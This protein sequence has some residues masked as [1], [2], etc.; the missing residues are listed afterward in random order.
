[1]KTLSVCMIVRNEEKT[2]E[3]AIKNIHLFADQLVI[4]DTGST[5]K[6]VEIAKK[7]TNEVYFFEWCDNFA[8]AQNFATSFSKCD[9]DTKWDADFE[10]DANSANR[11]LQAKKND[12]DGSNLIY[13]TWVIEHGDKGEP[14]KSVVREFIFKKDDFEYKYPIHVA[15]TPKDKT[16][17]KSSVHRDVV[18]HHMKDRV[19]KKGRYTQTMRLVKE[20]V[21]KYPNEIRFVFYL[22]E[23]LMFEN[24]YKEA[25]PI[26]KK[27][28]KLCED[29]NS[30]IAMIANEKLL[31]CYLGLDKIKKAFKLSKKK[32]KQ[33]SN[34][35]RYILIYADIL[36]L[37]NIDEAIGS[38]EKYISMNYSSIDTFSGFDIERFYVYPRII[39]GK[40]YLSI[41]KKKEA[42]IFLNEAL[43]KTTQSKTKLDI[44]NLLLK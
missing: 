1:M 15:I 27:Y 19:E 20:R 31:R 24:L 4:V 33:Y 40:Y 41:G 30:E 29:Q 32:Y 35:P 26:W 14:R 17:I 22:G 8:A 2:L 44:N 12:F 36:S 23:E 11:I 13:F 5:D 16:I 7:Y 10:I 21:K 43:N 34:F 25:I 3:N 37:I 6:T 39:L 18:I 9:F 28:I 42:N 38:Y